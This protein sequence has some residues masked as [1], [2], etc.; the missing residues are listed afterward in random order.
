V[1]LAHPC[2]GWEPS[3]GLRL[4]SPPSAGPLPRL[5]APGAFYAI[6]KL[7]LAGGGRYRC[8][9]IGVLPPFR[10]M[11]ALISMGA[12]LGMAH[13]MTRAGL[14]DKVV[15]LIGDS[16]FFHAG[17]PALANAVLQHGVAPPLSS[18]TTPPA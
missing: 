13:G 6:N 8:Y 1:G 5:P 12:S 17:L 9:A 3:Q 18:T 11:D 7:K 14:P 4:L 15:A 2:E 10:A 16:T